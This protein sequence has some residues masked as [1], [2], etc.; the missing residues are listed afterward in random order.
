MKRNLLG[1]LCA[2]LV[3]EVKAAPFCTI[4]TQAV[5]NSKVTC[6][7]QAEQV[8]PVYYT[9]CGY[10]SPCNTES[11]TSC[12]DVFDHYEKIGEYNFKVD[13]TAS[14]LLKTNNQITIAF[15]HDNEIETRIDHAQNIIYGIDFSKL[16]T[17]EAG[18]NQFS[19]KNVTGE[20]KIVQADLSKD[21]QV[22]NDAFTKLNYNKLTKDLLIPVLDKDDLKHVNMNLTFTKEFGF[23]KII[24]WGYEI[25]PKFI[26]YME[27]QNAEK[28]ARIN[29]KHYF[30]RIPERRST[31]EI[32][33]SNKL[34]T[35]PNL[36]SPESYVKSKNIKTVISKKGE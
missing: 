11:C 1:F 6:E 31:V 29:L 7:F 22:L 3:F 34:P 5:L 19:V 10:D 12:T 33:V 36:V 15:N 16:K 8:K 4:N 18:I 20:I 2:F 23:D 17:V 14:E 21:Y 26:E 35:L 28:F 13:V 9:Q 27:N 30:K 25:K 32:R 24:Y